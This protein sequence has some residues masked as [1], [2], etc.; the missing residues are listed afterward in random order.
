MAG[1]GV[2]FAAALISNTEQRL[3]L[4]TRGYTIAALT[5]SIIAILAYFHLIPFSELFL[6]FD[7][8][9]GTFN[10][11]NV[12]GAFLVFPA[13]LAFQRVLSASRA[14]ALRAGIALAVMLMALLLSFSRAAWGQLAG[15]GALLMLVM[16]ITTH[17]SKE[18]LRIVVAAL[19][20][21]FVVALI[22]LALLSVDRV[23]ELFKERA[24]LD[25]AHD[26]GHFGRFGRHVLGFALALETPLGIGPYAFGRIFPEDPHNTFLNA[27]MCGGWISGICYPA[28][29]L[30]TAV[31]GV[32][33]LFVPTPWQRAYQVVFCAFVGVVG[34]SLLIDIDHWRHYFLLLG[35]MWGLMAATRAYRLEPV[36]ASG[37]RI[38][39]AS[40]P[41]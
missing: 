5:A 3:A 36:A 24:S 27:F 15:T 20:G 1:T 13:L 28:I 7:R 32:A 16:L 2:F 4:L 26:T 39:R 18:R 35:A 10:D 34:E 41:A 21:I 22:L 23:A 11:P 38:F 31:R 29:V 40:R 12:L 25:Q 9:R 37:A 17:S 30:V 14:Q 33:F 6:R 19:F 8:A